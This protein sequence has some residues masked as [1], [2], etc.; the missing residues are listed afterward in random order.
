[1]NKVIFSKEAK[2]KLDFLREQAKKSKVEKSII[3][4]LQ[5]KIELLKLNH[6][7]GHP[8]AKKLIPRYYIQ[9]YEIINL[10]RFELPNF[11]RVLYTTQNNKIKIIAFIIDIVNHKKYNKRFKYKN[12]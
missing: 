2:E 10:F 11:W 1:M 6:H 12:K 9:K 5:K 7:Y 4:A 8:I 3:S